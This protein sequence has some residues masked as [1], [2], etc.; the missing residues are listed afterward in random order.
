MCQIRLEKTVFW[1]GQKI[2]K[3]TSIKPVLLLVLKNVFQT[4]HELSKTYVGTTFG[5]R[6]SK[7]WSNILVQLIGNPAVPH[8]CFNV[9]CLICILKYS[10]DLSKERGSSNGNC[11][12]VLS[13]AMCPQSSQPLLRCLQLLRWLRCFQTESFSAFKN[14]TKLFSTGLKGHE[15][16]RVYC[17]IKIKIVKHGFHILGTQFPCFRIEIREHIIPD[18]LVLVT[19]AA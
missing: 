16:Q 10:E 12:A 4:L 14:N 19:F 8:Q 3:Q 5:R 11:A 13:L 1:P 15:I 18:G 2:Q 9:F 6:Q 7:C 17:F